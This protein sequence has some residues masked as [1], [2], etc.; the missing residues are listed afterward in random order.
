MVKQLPIVYGIM[1]ENNELLPPDCQDE[2][3]NPEITPMP[4]LT[5][6]ATHLPAKFL[7]GERGETTTSGA[8][9]HDKPSCFPSCFPRFSHLMGS[10]RRFFSGA[11]EYIPSPSPQ[12]HEVGFACL[13]GGLTLAATGVACLSGGVPST[14]RFRGGGGGRG[15]Y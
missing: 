9:S 5:A 14:M 10:A 7:G 12:A 13:L 8:A 15:D 1:L 2:R 3:G 6:T 11:S 4:V